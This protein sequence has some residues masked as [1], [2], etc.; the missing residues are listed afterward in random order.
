M[1]TSGEGLGGLTTCFPDKRVVSLSQP[2]E[3]GPILKTVK[4]MGGENRAGKQAS[5]TGLPFEHP[6]ESPRGQKREQGGSERGG[7]GG[8]TAPHI[9]EPVVN[10]KGGWGRFPTS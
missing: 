10:P 8:G 3:R 6:Q 5:P 4:K 9:K 1:D 7:A 2:G